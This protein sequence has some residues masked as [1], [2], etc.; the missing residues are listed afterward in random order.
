MSGWRVVTKDLYA[1]RGGPL[2]P[3]KFERAELTQCTL[4]A[5]LARA[6][7]LGLMVCT[8]NSRGSTCRGRWKLTPRGID[9]CEGRIELVCPRTGPSGQAG[10]KAGSGMR[11]VA[12][13]LKALPRAGEIQLGHE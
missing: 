5:G 4:Y 3:R 11:P 13:W 8:T 7:E 9:W 12:T 2:H 6:K 1:A 10:R